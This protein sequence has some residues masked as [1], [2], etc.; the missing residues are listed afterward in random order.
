MRVGGSNPCPFGSRS[1]REGLGGRVGPPQSHG[2][3]EPLHF[4]VLSDRS[5]QWAPVRFRHSARMAA[6]LSCIHRKA[7]LATDAERSSTGP[8]TGHEPGKAF[9]LRQLCACSVASRGAPSCLV[10]G[11]AGASGRPRTAD[12]GTRHAPAADAWATRGPP[13]GSL[14]EPALD[15]AQRT[16]RI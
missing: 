9:M 12:A 4:M 6:P 15:Q 1:D 3:G 2:P 5:M 13:Q 14:Q 7:T 11:C 8:L 10:S 16:G